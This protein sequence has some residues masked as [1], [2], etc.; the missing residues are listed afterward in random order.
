M[1]VGR[2]EA[3]RH[4]WHGPWHSLVLHGQPCRY[5]AAL[6]TR[7]AAP[8]SAAAPTRL[9]FSGRLPSGQQLHRLLFPAQHQHNSC[10]C[11]REAA[12]NRGGCLQSSSPDCSARA[13]DSA[14]LKAPEKPEQTP[15]C[16]EPAC[17]G[18]GPRSSPHAC[19]MNELCSG[20]TPFISEGIV[21]IMGG[22]G[23]SARTGVCKAPGSPPP[24]CPSLWQ[25][26][27]DTAQAV[28]AGAVSPGGSQGACPTHPTYLELGR[29][30]GSRHCDGRHEPGQQ[31]QSPSAPPGAPVTAAR[32]WSECTAGWE[33]KRHG[34]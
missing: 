21:C 9:G 1:T 27:G 2:Q 24:S 11:L 18:Q 3:A 33:N 13:A 22:L 19:H 32:C 12:G 17:S 25:P 4:A 34:N 7:R 14:E 16:A 15:A 5:A 10:Q 23:C 20:L 30:A 31:P 8:F 26:D 28:G 6:V 29:Q